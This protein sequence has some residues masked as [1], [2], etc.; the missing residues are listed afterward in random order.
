MI[1]QKGQLLTLGKNQFKVESVFSHHIGNVVFY[2]LNP[3]II[4]SE[5][6]L[7]ALT[8]MDNK[9]WIE[10]K[11]LMNHLQTKQAHLIENELEKSKAA[12]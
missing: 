6:E 4:Q 5:K 8:V 3:T 11:Q 10:S 7:K 9:Y 2:Q 12:S 1:L